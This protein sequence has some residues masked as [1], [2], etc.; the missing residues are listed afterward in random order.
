VSVEVTVRG[1]A[2]RRAQPERATVHVSVE[3]EGG[4][5]DDVFGTVRETAATLSAQLSQLADVGA[6]AEWSSDQLRTWSER[7][8]HKSG[9][10][11]PQVHHARAEFRATFTD[12]DELS[13]WI[14]GTVALD[15]VMVSHVE[16]AL[17]D[18]HRDELIEQVRAAAVADAV[19]KASSYANNLGLT[20]LQPVA[21]A[22]P[23]M[24]GGKRHDEPMRAV[25]LAATYSADSGGGV[26]FT[27]QDVVV[28]A[29]VD[30]RFTAEP[31]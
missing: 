7:P 25:A 20:R 6:A 18:A 27:P 8:W 28:Q 1:S 13:R 9:H 4:S 10:Q 30:A 21:I 31:A 12:F 24:L 3:S 14:A 16:W 11:L 29:A 19:A 23:G 2:E 26:R 15:G 17:T 5:R 22:D